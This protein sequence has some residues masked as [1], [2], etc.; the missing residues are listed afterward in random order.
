MKIIVQVMN[1]KDSKKP[2]T[3]VQH[4]LNDLGL[5]KDKLEYLAAILKKNLLSKGVIASFY[6]DRDKSFGKYFSVDQKSSLIYCHDNEGLMHELKP[7]CYKI[8]ECYFSSTHLLLHW[9][10]GNTIVEISKNRFFLLA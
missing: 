1:D 6:R 2:E 9:L 5:S 4:V 7:N 10:R 3:L 8:E